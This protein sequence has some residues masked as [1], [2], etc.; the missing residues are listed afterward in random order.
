ML[1]RRLTLAQQIIT[2]QRQEITEMRNDP[3]DLYGIS[4]PQPFA[5]GRRALI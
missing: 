1:L 5:P 4:I 2:T 3:H